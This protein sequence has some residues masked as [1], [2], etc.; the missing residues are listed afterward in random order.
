MN[1]R[2]KTLQ[3]VGPVAP[4]AQM[5]EA[6]INIVD[7]V[8]FDVT[9]TLQTYRRERIERL[10]S[11]GWMDIKAGTIHMPIGR[12]MDLVIQDQKDEQKADQDSSRR[13]S[14]SDRR[15][16]SSPSRQSLPRSLLPRGRAASCRAGR[17][18]GRGGAPRRARRQRNLHGHRGQPRGAS[19]PDGARQAGGADA[20]L[21]RLPH[22]LQPGAE[23]RDQGAQPERAAA[24]RRLLRPHR[25]LLSHRHHSRGAPAPGR[26]LQTLAKAAKARPVDW[27][28]LTGGD[29]AIRTLADSVGFRYRY[30][31]ESGQ[32][33]HP[34]VSMVL[35]PDGKIS[36]YL[37]GIDFR[38][39]TC[40]SPSWR[41]R[42]A[43]SAPRSTA[44][45]CAASSTIPP[46]ASTTST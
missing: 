19:R 11:W 23:G 16:V 8:P 15:I 20:H 29:H 43:G 22:A 2:E 12:A 36:R 31:K 9:R 35:G 25:Q 1:A 17:A 4:A 46:R 37:Y 38:R 40:A 28:Y 14:R 30:D 34:A 39:A 10:S 3:P 6:E 18:G 5:G 42:K 32:Y 7:Q 44:S 41:R 21:F 45:S 13:R 33:E 26:V 24:A 27:P